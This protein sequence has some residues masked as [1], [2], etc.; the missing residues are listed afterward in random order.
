MKPVHFN[1]KSE[2]K[3]RKMQRHAPPLICFPHSLASLCFLSAVII[4]IIFLA[5]KSISSP[6]L[7]QLVA[8]VRFF[9]ALV[10]DVFP[11]LC[12][13]PADH[14]YPCFTSPLCLFPR[15]AQ[16]PCENLR[17]PSTYPGN[18]LPHHPGQGNFEDFTC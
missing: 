11:P 5:Y 13:F 1:C 18:M 17:T 9:C 8:R 2:P 16:A 3:Q 7:A 10:Y 4:F 6:L 12:T 14:S 15:L